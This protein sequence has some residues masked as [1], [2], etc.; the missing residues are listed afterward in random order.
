M[1]QQPLRVKSEV[2][3]KGSDRKRL[4]G[5]LQRQWPLTTTDMLK[6]L[7]PSRAEILL[8]RV[9]VGSGREYVNVYFHQLQPIVFEH[10]GIVYPTV[11][12]AWRFSNNMTIVTTWSARA[13]D[14]MRGGDLPLQSLHFS[15]DEQ[16]KMCQYIQPGRS[17]CIASPETNK[18]AIAVG[19]A[20]LTAS[21]MIQ[22]VAKGTAVITMHS[23]GDH[24][25]AAGCKGQ[26]PW[27]MTRLPTSLKDVKEK[28]LT[29]KGSKTYKSRRDG[30][31]YGKTTLAN[32]IF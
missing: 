16:Q 27:I 21:R 2:I 30:S 13:S 25:W 11:Y 3:L 32:R 9:A 10:N 5:D 17:C 12:T 28:E 19:Q 14:L 7:I 31:S 15:S 4:R 23:Y 1:F 8:Y 24:L 29:I 20:C 18:S 6:S 26:P 22:G